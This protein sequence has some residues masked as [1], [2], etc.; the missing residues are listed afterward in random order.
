MAGWLAALCLASAAAAQIPAATAETSPP[1]PSM[2]ASGDALR[3]EI[4]RK[5]AALQSDFAIL[6][7]KLEAAAQSETYADRDALLREVDSLRQLERLYGQQLALC[8]V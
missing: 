3:D 4:A 7:R 1:T 5:R 8:G 2:A 6:R